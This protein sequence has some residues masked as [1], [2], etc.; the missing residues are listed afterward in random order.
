MSGPV[1]GIKDAITRIDYDIR[2]RDAKVAEDKGAK[3]SAKASKTVG[4]VCEVRRAAQ[5]TART[6]YSMGRPVSA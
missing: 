5:P 6:G 2:M 1:G 4:R 3:Q